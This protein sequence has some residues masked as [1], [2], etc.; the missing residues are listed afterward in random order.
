[1]ALISRARAQT[2]EP[3]AAAP[4]VDAPDAEIYEKAKLHIAAGGRV[5]VD[6][7]TGSTATTTDIACPNCG[8][9]IRVENVD[10]DIRAAEMHCLD[11]HF[12]FAQRLMRDADSRQPAGDERPRGRF[13][14]GHR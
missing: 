2:A 10:R 5:V 8:G 11:C 1:M 14:R 13:L 9:T 7:T 3:E 12:R 4:A 6:L